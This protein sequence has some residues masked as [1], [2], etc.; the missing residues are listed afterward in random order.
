MR[1]C[2][3]PLTTVLAGVVVGGFVG[4]APV[5]LLTE[6]IGWRAVELCLFGLQ[7]LTLITLVV[8]W[9]IERSHNNKCV[10]CCQHQLESGVVTTKDRKLLHHA[11]AKRL[12]A[13]AERVVATTCRKSGDGHVKVTTA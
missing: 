8:L 4:K 9:I 3:H 6:Q 2:I 7:V 12:S 1:P 11:I 13:S 5:A 10:N